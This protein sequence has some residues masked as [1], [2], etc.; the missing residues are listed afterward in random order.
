MDHQQ[1][2][3]AQCDLK[4]IAD[5][6]QVDRD[7]HRVTA[8]GEAHGQVRDGM[9]VRPENSKLFTDLTFLAFLLMLDQRT[10]PSSD[11]PL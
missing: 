9:P 6:R 5:S 4:V 10:S 1:I 3:A 11:T 7:Q 8:R 2:L